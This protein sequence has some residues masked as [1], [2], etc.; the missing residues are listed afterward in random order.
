MEIGWKQYGNSMEIV[1]IEIVWKL[2]MLW[3]Q[4]GKAWKQYGSWK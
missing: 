2:E 4:Y 3:K 1:A